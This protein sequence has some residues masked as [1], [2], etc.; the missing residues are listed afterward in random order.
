MKGKL[1]FFFIQALWWQG[2]CRQWMTVKAFSLQRPF[3][4][5]YAH[6]GRRGIAP[7]AEFPEHQRIEGA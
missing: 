4:T 6:Y 5:S 7:P 2:V 3:D 1:V